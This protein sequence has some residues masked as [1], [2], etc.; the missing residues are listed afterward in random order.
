MKNKGPILPVEVA[1]VINSNILLASAYLSEFVSNGTIKV[2]KVKVGGSP[3]YFLPN[4]EAKLENFIPKLNEKEQRAVQELK[5][6]KVL[7]DSELQP[8]QRVGLRNSRDFAKP[9]EVV[10]NNQ[11]QLFWRWFLTP[12]SEVESIIRKKYFKQK[13]TPAHTEK[14]SEN[15][16]EKQKPNVRQEHS[17]QAPLIKTHDTVLEDAKG[18]FTE[19]QKTE[20]SFYDKIRDFFEEHNIKTTQQE[21]IKKNKHYWFIAENPASIGYITYYCEAKNKKTIASSDL[22][23]AFVK[24]Q[25]KRLPLLYITNGKPNKST[26]EMM[27][28]EFKNIILKII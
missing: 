3:V 23:D 26:Q 15:I 8:L 6:N 14:A 20:K 2:S 13:V 7:K 16:L 18:K 25:N 5:Q 28:N 9:V 1:K 12:K 11:K 17:I 4:Q 22:S 19:Q 24:A 27:D 21:I 10:I